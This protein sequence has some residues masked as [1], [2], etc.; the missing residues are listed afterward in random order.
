MVAHAMAQAAAQKPVEHCAPLADTVKP[1]SGIVNPKV[2]RH[3]AP[4]LPAG[5]PTPFQGTV[6]LEATVMPDGTVCGVTVTKSLD[7]SPGSFDEE[8]I[9]AAKR[10]TFEPGQSDGKPVPV[11]VAIEMT[12]TKRAALAPVVR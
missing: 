1:G 5:T 8:A 12:F 10:W 3:V 11:R 7:P 6:E 4:R 2:K 9:K